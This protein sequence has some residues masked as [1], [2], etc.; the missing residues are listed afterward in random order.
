M[1]ICQWFRFQ[2]SFENWI[3][4][5]SDMTTLTIGGEICFKPLSRIGFI[6]TGTISLAIVGT[7]EFQTSFE[8]W[9]HR[10]KSRTRPATASFCRS[11][12]PLSRIGFIATRINGNGRRIAE[13]GVSNLFRE[14]DSSRLLARADWR[15]SR[16][17][18]QTSF[19]NWIHRDKLSGRMGTWSR[20]VSNLF[21]ELDSSRPIVTVLAMCCMF[22]FKPLSRIGFIAT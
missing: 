2:T 1:N 21:R 4:R 12:K 20:H 15:R 17:E 13:R 19:E 11:F 6:A 10:D 9:I 22:G 8:N 5:D 7:E 18:F 14:L 16:R 3:H